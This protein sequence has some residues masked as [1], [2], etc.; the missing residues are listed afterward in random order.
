MKVREDLQSFVISQVAELSGWFV[1]VVRRGKEGDWL[2]SICP[3]LPHELA[4]KAGE[5]LKQYMEVR[6]RTAKHIEE[7]EAIG[8]TIRRGKVM[9]SGHVC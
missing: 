4:V 9:L 2:L 7:F 6:L 5:K 1:N 3:S 8:K